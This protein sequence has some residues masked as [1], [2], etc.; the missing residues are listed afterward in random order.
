MW[1]NWY[2]NMFLSLSTF[3]ARRSL[4]AAV[5]CA[6]LALLA[7]TALP[8]HASDLKI[9]DTAPDFSLPGTDGKTYKLSDYK[10]KQAVVLAWFPRAF[11]PG[12]TLE[13]KSLKENGEAIRKFDAVYFAVSLDPIEGEKG[14]KKFAESLGLDFPLLSDA[15]KAAVAAYGTQH[16]E[17]PVAQR[18]TFYI[19]KDGKILAIDKDVQTAT[20]GSDVAKRLKELGVSE[21]K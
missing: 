15:G 1:F 14:N 7:S 21:K 3:V 8:T 6:T 10:G 4:L 9:G 2:M 5:L 17:K 20:H 19:G 16:P 13:C 18:W 11:T 12:C